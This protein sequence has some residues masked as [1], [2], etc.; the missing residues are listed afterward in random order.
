MRVWGTGTTIYPF[1]TATNSIVATV[2]VLLNTIVASL[3]PAYKA[4]KIKPID[5][6]HFI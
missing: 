6:L 1:L 4:A 5:A 2:I 3:Y